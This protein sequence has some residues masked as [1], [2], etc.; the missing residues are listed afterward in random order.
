M[1]YLAKHK[2]IPADVPLIAELQQIIKAN[3]WA[4][5]R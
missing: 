2:R 4:K 1:K 3:G 5:K